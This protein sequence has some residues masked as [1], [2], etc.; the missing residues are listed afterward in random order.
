M[1]Y[2][3][4]KKCC[5][6][7][8][9]KSLNA[10][11]NNKLSKDGLMADCKECHT[12]KRKEYQ[13]K[14]IDERKAYA[15]EFFKQ[16]MLSWATYFPKEMFCEICGVS[17]YFN[18]KDKMHSVHFDHINKETEKIIWLC[19]GQWLRHHPCTLANIEIWESCN[20]GKLCHR[21]NAFLPT[22]NREEYLLKVMK[23]VNSKKLNKED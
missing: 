8:N 22:E 18:K 12:K 21:C 13:L 5:I 11:W 2:E 4:N 1:K 9:L 23:Y 15:K 6:C 19:P 17:L 16:N 20:F 10:F 7:K 3:V 14:H